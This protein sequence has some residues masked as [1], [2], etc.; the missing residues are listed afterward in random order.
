VSLDRV[1]EWFPG[2]SSCLLIHTSGKIRDIL[3]KMANK[4]DLYVV[5][6]NRR[7]G[8]K[9]YQIVDKTTEKVLSFN[10][11]IAEASLAQNQGLIMRPKPRKI[12]RLLVEISNYEELNCVMKTGALFFEDITVTEAVHILA[13]KGSILI[14]HAE[15]GKYGLFKEGKMLIPSTT[16]SEHSLSDG[17]SVV[18]SKKTD[19]KFPLTVLID[20]WQELNCVRKTSVWFSADTTIAEARRKIASKPS[21]NIPTDNIDAYEL[22]V[23]N[24]GQVRS[25]PPPAFATANFL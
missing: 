15:E 3:F 17:D 22:I 9:N 13:R 25:P 19:Q 23:L 1:Y 4:S 14:P 20:D 10:M 24:T 2:V 7:F 8:V 21:I 12:I 5:T 11:T 18:L 16:L 6:S